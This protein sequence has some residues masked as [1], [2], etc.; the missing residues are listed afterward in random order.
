MYAL[1][2]FLGW[3]SGLSVR[4]KLPSVFI[5]V[6]II[7]LILWIFYEAR[8][9]KA[10]LLA[11]IIGI[12]LMVIGALSIYTLWLVLFTLNTLT[13]LAIVGTVPYGIFGVLLNLESLHEF[14][15]IMKREIIRW[16]KSF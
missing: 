14:V 11:W 15:I 5:I 8:F 1:A 6:E 13:V 9:A 3:I 16:R 2:L 10:T 12:P 7:G 4:A